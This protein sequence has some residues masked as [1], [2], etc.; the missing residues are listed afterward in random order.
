MYTVV[1]PLDLGSGGTCLGKVTSHGLHGCQRR[2]IALA[3]LERQSL[4]S[5]LHEHLVSSSSL[6]GELG[7]TVA[8]PGDKLVSLFLHSFL[9]EALVVGWL[10][11]GELKS[12]HSEDLW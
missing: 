6:V 8:I 12:F 2:A 11:E 9:S 3:S 5:S 4:V 10:V 1:C 7:R